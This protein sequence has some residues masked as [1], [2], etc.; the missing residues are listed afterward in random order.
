MVVH[1]LLLGGLPCDSVRR[2]EEPIRLMANADYNTVSLAARELLHG[3][4]Q[5]EPKRRLAAA[6][7]EMTSE[8]SWTNDSCENCGVPIRI[9]SSAVDS[10]ICFHQS[11][12]LYKAVTTAM[13][14]QLLDTEP[15]QN[16]KDQF[17]AMDSDGNGCL[18]KSELSYALASRAHPAPTVAADIASWLEVVFAA[19][20]TDGSGEIEYS[21]YLAA[22]LNDCSCRSDQAIQAAFRLFDVDGSGKISCR[23][24][25]RV[26]DMMPED[27]VKSIGEFDAD[28]DGEINLEEFKNIVAHGHAL[29]PFT[30][31]PS[32]IDPTGRRLFKI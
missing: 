31:E 19:I 20:D 10:F 23:E 1:V 32:S 16:I 25:A 5:I 28:G 2:G 6:R 8:S 3:L 17:L 12:M 13:A 29:D 26:I 30:R 27:I 7:I 24:F 11:S 18:S 9:S 22:V 14:M 15:I 4:L 21:E